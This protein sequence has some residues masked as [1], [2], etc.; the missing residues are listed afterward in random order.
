MSRSALIVGILIL[1]FVVVSLV[2]GRGEFGVNRIGKDQRQ[3]Q[4]NP[5][6]DLHR[7]KHLADG[8][9]KDLP[10]H[11]VREIISS[12]WDII[13][14][15]K[16]ESTP[17]S[18]KLAKVEQEAS[19]Y[20]QIQHDI[21][22]E[23]ATKARVGQL[24]LFVTFLARRTR[25]ALQVPRASDE[26]YA[27]ANST[28]LLEYVKIGLKELAGTP[29][30]SPGNL[31][32][33]C[34]A[35]RHQQHPR[36]RGVRKKR[37]ELSMRGISW[38]KALKVALSRVA[39]LLPAAGDGAPG[40]PQGGGHRQGPPPAGP[41][42]D[43][44]EESRQRGRLAVSP[45]RRWR[46]TGRSRAAGGGRAHE[47]ASGVGPAG[48]EGRADQGIGVPGRLRSRQIGQAGVDARRLQCGASG[49]RG[50]Y[51]DRRPRT[52]ADEHAVE[53]VV[54]RL[55]KV[56]APEA[57]VRRAD[58]PARGG[59]RLAPHDG[60]RVGGTAPRD[61]PRPSG[62]RAR[63]APRAA[64]QPR[65]RGGGPPEARPGA[66]G[67]RRRHQRP[68]KGGAWR[69]GRPLFRGL[70]AAVHLR[71]HARRRERPHRARGQVLARRPGRGRLP[72]PRQPQRTGETSL[73]LR[74]PVDGL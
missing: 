73:V 8:K 60:P 72:R 50:A 62:E 58:V 20:E 24:K 63:H 51:A 16:H 68:P 70:P 67:A 2:S 22:A 56:L 69:L 39:E 44:S 61:S 48:Q 30:W 47:Q 5:I 37:T 25:D 11:A 74:V 34:I 9:N 18:Q 71:G 54:A 32:V 14:S 27:V 29:E 40:A 28:G 42:R 59:C 23:Q 36:A 43:Q 46:R 65:E 45:G 41:R 7:L 53:A 38:R 31:G 3:S 13:L 64:P 1:S 52:P 17:A 49:A 57:D 10:S 15:E 12:S 55:Q 21:S 4:P 35:G 26:I 19:F 6:D 33:S 66:E